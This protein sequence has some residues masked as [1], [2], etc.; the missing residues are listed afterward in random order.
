MSNN[1]ENRTWVDIGDG[2]GY[3]I[4]RK[5]RSN[6][7]EYKTPTSCSVCHF[8]MTN[9]LDATS[10]LKFKCCVQCYIQFIEGRPDRWNEGWRP[11]GEEFVRYIE[12]R[13]KFG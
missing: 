9:N 3:W 1:N 5:M 7:D 2:T 4:E 8:M 13:K 6:K 11:E 10:Y 12:K